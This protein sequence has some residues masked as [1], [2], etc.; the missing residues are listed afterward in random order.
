MYKDIAFSLFLHTV[1]FIAILIYSLFSY[2][3]IVLSPINVSLVSN[4]VL[5]SPIPYKPLVVNKDEDANQNKSTPKSKAPVKKQVAKPKKIDTPKQDSKTQNNQDLNKN[6]IQDA[7][8]KDKPSIKKSAPSKT[9][10]YQKFK[11]QF[12][13]RLTKSSEKK[14]SKQ[15]PQEGKLSSE[16]LKALN[17]QIRGCWYGQGGHNINANLAVNLILTMN[18]DG[19]I[20]KIQVLNKKSYN[21]PLREALLQQVLRALHDNKCQQLN[22][23][24]GRYNSWQ[25][26]HIE[27][28]PRKF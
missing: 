22:L 11:Q 24:N 28:N 3:T 2:R 7:K 8:V 15:S 17:D 13:N 1:A 5:K 16:E 9:S 20:K 6:K 18:R 10:E 14:A 21:T 23:P 12:L 26:I 25:T 27:F 19:T 4:D